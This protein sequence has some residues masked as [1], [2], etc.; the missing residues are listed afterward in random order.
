MAAFLQKL[1]FSLTSWDIKMMLTGGLASRTELNSLQ[2]PSSS[3][4]GG[5]HDYRGPYQRMKWKFCLCF[6]ILYILYNINRV[7]LRCLAD[8]VETNG[9]SRHFRKNSTPP[10]I[11]TKSI[12]TPRSRSYQEHIDSKESG[13]I[14]YNSRSTRN[15]QPRNVEPISNDNVT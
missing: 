6:Y 2:T 10:P 7:M 5:L 9:L 13:R 3:W 14:M 8:S 11:S 4:T 15:Q 1:G 12:Q